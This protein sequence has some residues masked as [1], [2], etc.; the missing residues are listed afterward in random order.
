MRILVTGASGFIGGNIVETFAA[1][2]LLHILATGRTYTTAFQKF[3]NTEYVQ[4]DL[5]TETKEMDCDVCIHCAGLADDHSSAQQYF[6]N[7]IQ[8]TENLLK[9]IPNCRQFIYIS[10][11]SVYDFSDEKPKKEEEAVLSNRLSLYGH[12]K[13]QAENIIR[14]SGIHSVYILRP[15][16][17]YGKGDRVLLPRILQLIR[18]NRLVV[19][20]SL[21]VY[22]SL[23]HI[24]NLCEAVG[25]A[26][27]QNRPGIHVYNIADKKPYLI[28][29]VFGE[30]M[31]KKCGSKRFIHIPIPV[32]KFLI[33]INFIT[34]RKSGLSTQSLKYITQQQVL[35]IKNAES[36]LHYEAAYEFY[37]SIH[38][39]D[40]E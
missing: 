32:V 27:Q 3:R 24:L 15:R 31:L 13:L 19:P 36:E 16:A 11:S 14:L 29:S 10:S 35:D 18:D 5:S 33:I 12:S 34:K 8:A 40:I 7:N 1:N 23:T 21:Q 38:Q 6:L 26:V 20:G 30:I 2:P 28:K 17:V 25:K 4:W 22:G 9:S 37:T 39:L